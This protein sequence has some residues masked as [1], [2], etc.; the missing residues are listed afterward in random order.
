MAW[1]VAEAGYS[2]W[3]DA[4]LKERFGVRRD[5]TAEP[6]G[7]PSASW[8]GWVAAA[9]HAT[10]PLK[11]LCLPT[12]VPPRRGAEGVKAAGSCRGG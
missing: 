8:A 7:N 4:G 12:L 9:F 5:E 6:L 3:G 2:P 1:L 11:E 10:V